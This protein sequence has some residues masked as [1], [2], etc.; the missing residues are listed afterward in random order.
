[1][2][3]SQCGTQFADDSQFCPTCGTPSGVS[4]QPAQPQYQQPVQPQYQQ[5]VQPQYQQPVQPQYQQPVQ[6]QYQQPVYQQPKAPIQVAPAT[7]YQKKMAV[8]VALVAIFA[9]IAGV[10]N[11][12]CMV[13]LPVSISAELDKN[14]TDGMMEIDGSV[15][16][17]NVSTGILSEAFELADDAGVDASFT[18]AYVGLIL[19]GLINLA[20]A[21]VGILYYLRARNNMPLYEQ[22]FGGIVKGQS[23]AALLGIVGVVGCIL[24]ILCMM[25]V[26]IDESMQGQ[27]AAVS[28]GVPCITW[29]ALAIYGVLAGSQLLA[30]D[31]TEE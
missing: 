28:V 17:I 8:I 10:M 29:V 25:F 30:I 21:G 12:F 26:G 11:L 9:L 23:P 13:D 5:P 19:F 24:Q 4:S 6:P 14:M 22:F 16:G 20:I 7:A 3:C 2:F 18:M 15:G 31:K 1:M 27:S